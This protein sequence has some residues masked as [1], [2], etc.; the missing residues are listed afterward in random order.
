M[1]TIMHRL[2]LRGGALLALAVAAA[3]AGP[4]AASCGSAFCLVN[5]NWSVQGVWNEPGWRLD[6]RYEHIDQDQPRAGTRRVGVGEVP[7]HHDE[8]RT[9]NNN[10]LATLDYGITPDWGVSVIVP[11]VDR[12]HTH[13]HNHHGE[14]IPERWSFHDL[15]DAR[16]QGRW[17]AVLDATDTERAAFAGA[18]FGLKLPTSRIDVANPEGEV[19][20][21]SLQPGTGTTDLLLGAYYRQAIPAR[22]ASWFVQWQGQFAL[23][24]HAGFR[25]GNQMGLDYGWRYDATDALGLMLQANYRYKARDSGPE[26]EPQDSGGQ[27]LTL[28]PGVS[29]ALSPAMQVY[30]YVQVPL[31]QR[32]N[33][34]QLTSDWSATAGLSVQF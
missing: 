12:E 14:Q 7:A 13:I 8:V 9:R 25:A 28:A 1:G 29:Y 22:Q 27:F 33:G 20:E 26:A 24:A 31:W 4:A 11:Y 21:R 32:V 17:Q 16:V 15:G 34:V 30:A 6:L 3:S 18:T 5:T 10:V 19:A 2:R 23:D